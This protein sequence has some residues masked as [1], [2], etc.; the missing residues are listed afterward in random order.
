MKG[1][2][3]ERFY[4]GLTQNLETPVR[5]HLAKVYATFTCA[6]LTAVAGFLA[7][8]LNSIQ[9]RAGIMSGIGMFVSLVCL[10]ATPYDGGKDKVQRLSLLGSFAFLTG[11]NLGPLLDM[12]VT[13]NPT[14][15]MQALLGTSVVS[16]CFSLSALY[17]PRAHYLYLGGVLLSLSSI[18]FSLSLM[19]FFFCSRFIFEFNLYVGL[20]VW[21][22]FILYDTQYIVE[23][24]RRG[25]KDYVIHSLLL[26]IDFVAVFQR[27]FFILMEKEERK[28]RKRKR[29]R[30]RERCRE[31]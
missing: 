31:D 18:L 20:G 29:E 14:L 4:R 3:L 27:L 9:I 19:N 28:K 15:V 30:E 8:T 2:N 17:A 22:T 23:M 16:A 10:L 11:F 12:A 21:C 1:I 6:A 7:H 13:V 25:D 24:A 26:F 5:K